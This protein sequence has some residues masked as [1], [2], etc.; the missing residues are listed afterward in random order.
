MVLHKIKILLMLT[1]WKDWISILLILV[2][3]YFITLHTAS[4]YTDL[5]FMLVA[6]SLSLAFGF[7]INDYFDA[8]YDKMKPIVRN[9]ISKN[10]ISK[11]HAAVFCIFL[12]VAC[13]VIGYY[14]LSF[15]TFVLLVALCILYFVYSS[16]PFRMKERAYLGIINHGMFYP[17]L[18]VAGYTANL[19]FNAEAVI[20]SISA[21]MLS[22]LG[23]ITQEIRD[24]DVDKK[25]K[26]KTTALEMGYIR[27]LTSLKYCFSG[28]Y[29]FFS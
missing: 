4:V 6:F 3:A 27:S 13:I 16:P 23:D 21:F 7:A 28:Q 10:L 2:L 19:S 11:L 12:L 9:V 5:V 14:F 15:K 25:S 24:M 29:I 8:P 1:R 17:I 26:F 20:F 18:F 22:L